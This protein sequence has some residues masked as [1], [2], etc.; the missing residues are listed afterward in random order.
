MKCG[1]KS[2]THGP[3]NESDYLF[4]LA[5]AA[6]RENNT[7]KAIDL[8]R[9]AVTINPVHVGYLTALGELLLSD[10]R[11]GEALIVLKKALAFKP[12]CS[13]IYF[14]MGLAA[15]GLNDKRAAAQ[16]FAQ[17]GLLHPDCKTT[18]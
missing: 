2:G 5:Q 17:A 15:D 14:N 13:E 8:V 1:C 12:H 18:N 4:Q 7:K 3:L 6:L 9:R 10:R 11:F 16:Y